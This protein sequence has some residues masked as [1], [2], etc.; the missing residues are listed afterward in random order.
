M[1][2]LL[3]TR[4]MIFLFTWRSASFLLNPCKYITAKHTR[5]ERKAHSQNANEAAAR[6]KVTPTN[7]CHRICKLAKSTAP[8]TPKGSSPSCVA[9][10]SKTI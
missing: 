5:H 8:A 10:S 9:V 7:K 2:N 4:A 1:V 3:A 6:H